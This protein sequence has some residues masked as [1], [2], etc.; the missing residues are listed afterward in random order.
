MD[1]S[2]ASAGL[3]FLENGAKETRTPD[4]LHAIEALW[5][6]KQLQTLGWRLI[7][8]NY[9]RRKV[10][11]FVLLQGTNQA[12]ITVQIDQHRSDHC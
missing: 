2:D 5:T 11:R 12:K 3:A 8:T 10:R 9:V 6:P 7:N 1:R 4:P